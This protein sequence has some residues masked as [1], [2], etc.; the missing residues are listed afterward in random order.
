VDLARTY[1]Q[2]AVTRVGSGAPARRPRIA[3]VASLTLSLVNFRLELLRGLMQRGYDVYALAPDNDT[4]NVAR[5][6]LLG[7]RFLR[8]P[9][10]R[11]ATGPFDDLV[12]LM[13][14]WRAFRNIRPDIVL[15]Y[16]MKPIIYGGLAARLTGVPRRYAM[17]TGLGYVFIDRGRSLRTAGLRWLSVHL[18]RLALRGAERVLVYNEADA[19]E[20][21]AHAIVNDDVL[22]QVPGSGVDTAHFAASPPPDGPPVFLMVARLLRDKG[23]AE[24]AAAAR[25][26]R[27][28]YPEA[29]F[30]LLGPFDP[31]PAA[32]SPA[33]VDAWVAD[34]AIEYLGAKKDVRPFLA[35]CSVF[36]LPSYREGMSRTVLEAMA[37]GRAVVT[38]DAPGCAEPVEHGVTGFIAP[39]KNA[40][41]LAAAMEKF[42]T[43]P[44]LIRDMGARAR[45]RVEDHY[46]VHAVN[47][48]LFAAMRLD[49]AHMAG[50][51]LGAALCKG[52]TV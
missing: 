48:A 37:T 32:I 22:I 1:E 5:L 35:D 14:L 26:L 18:Y 8:I 39:V 24:Y 42:V 6:E 51:V 19:A 10:K 12:T 4:E 25:M 15:S 28:R 49:Q 33:E 44:T 40:E 21:R 36:V 11:T 45:L 27:A 9:M 31:N 29:R 43:D 23:V 17:V 13:T 41:A 7:I 46:E 52:S 38:S 47:R 3:V 34:G 16:T 2:H 50:S 20:L 30:Q